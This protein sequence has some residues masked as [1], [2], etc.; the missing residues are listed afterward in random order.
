[1]PSAAVAAAVVPPGNSGVNQYTESI[2]T[3]GGPT[4]GTETQERSPAKTLGPRRAQRLE[5]L[6]PEGRATAELAARTA[7]TGGR[8]GA[9]TPG[10]TGAGGGNG[11]GGGSKGTAPGHGGVALDTAEPSGS[12]GLGD[13]LGQATGTSGAG[14]S[15]TLTLL[16][17]LAAVAGS[18][19]YMLRRY[20]RPA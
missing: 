4:I 13:V 2:P 9:A 3:A 19:A 11:K 15:G 10:E 7:P 16:A 17:I 5:S 18:V 14:G 6:G 12:S 8:P 20:R 1:M